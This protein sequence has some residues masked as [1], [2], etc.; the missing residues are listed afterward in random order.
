MTI[1]VCCIERYMVWDVSPLGKWLP[2]PWHQ[3]I[4]SAYEPQQDILYILNGTAWDSYI[5]QPT[6]NT[7]QLAFDTSPTLTLPLTAQMITPRQI[8]QDYILPTSYL[9]M[10]SPPLQIT[11]SPSDYN[12]YISSKPSAYHSFY[13]TDTSPLNIQLL[14]DSYK[15]GQLLGAFLMAATGEKVFYYYAFATP[16]NHT[17]IQHYGTIP[18]SHTRKA[19]QRT[20]LTTFLSILFLVSYLHTSTSVHQPTIIASKSAYIA[21]IIH[22]MQTWGHLSAQNL[23]WIHNQEHYDLISLIY[24]QYL[25]WKRL[26]ILQ[27]NPSLISADDKLI[28][29]G[30]GMHN[31]LNHITSLHFD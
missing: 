1:S 28:T 29:D 30:P 22:D 16:T 9:P 5:Y 4:Q 17:T 20:E 21:A 8:H 11:L 7:Y 14:Q 25:Q 23:I 18:N 6:T 24:I 2:R 12:T 26:V 10:I 15:T 31:N 13:P 27:P 3:L 19:T